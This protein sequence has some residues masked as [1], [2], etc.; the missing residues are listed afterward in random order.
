MTSEIRKI[1]LIQYS[2]IIIIVCGLTAGM[3]YDLGHKMPLWVTISFWT[4]IVG[5][6]IFTFYSYLKIPKITVTDNKIVSSNISNEI[7]IR[8]NEIKSIDK[9]IFQNRIYSIGTY[10]IIKSTKN[11][12]LEIPQ[13]IY[14]NETELIQNIKEKF[15]C[16]DSFTLDTISNKE[17]YKQLN[18][19]SNN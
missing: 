13:K 18:Q 16:I 5:F 7:E 12:S 10:Y 2:F 1:Y 15:N 8:I 9:D 19:K 6:P 4:I 14:K 11:I 17:D 3:L